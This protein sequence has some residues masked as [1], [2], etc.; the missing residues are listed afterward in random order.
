MMAT[1]EETNILEI[2]DTKGQKESLRWLMLNLDKA[3]FKYKK[4]GK[5]CS[6]QD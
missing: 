4:D 6:L 2:N 3:G 1:I 5:S